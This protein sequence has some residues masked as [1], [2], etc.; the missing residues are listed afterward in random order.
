M[1]LTYLTHQPMKTVDNSRL[2]GWNKCRISELLLMRD[3][4]EDFGKGGLRNGNDLR[5]RRLEPL[6]R[7]LLRL[8][9]FR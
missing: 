1:A 3:F 4:L 7:R 9:R 2:E 6:K 8:R 5:E